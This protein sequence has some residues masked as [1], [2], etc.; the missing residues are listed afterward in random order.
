MRGWMDWRMHS[1]LERSTE[2]TKSKHVNT[3]ATRAGVH[4]HRACWGRGRRR[5]SC[6]TS[7]RCGSRSGGRVSSRC[8]RTDARRRR[9]PRRWRWRLSAG[10]GRPRRRD[11]S[12]SRRASWPASR[13]WRRRSRKR[14]RRRHTLRGNGARG[15]YRTKDRAGRN[16]QIVIS[17]FRTRSTML[18][19]RNFKTKLNLHNTIF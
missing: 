4:T 18:T 17:L 13:T 3:L 16:Y 2:R 6:N 7:S 11:T 9:C 5:T 14:G 15:V 12:G 19:Q 1:G 8:S 10:A